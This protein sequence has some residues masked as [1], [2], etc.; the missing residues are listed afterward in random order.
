MRLLVKPVTQK[1]A[2]R[3]AARM[4]RKLDPISERLLMKAYELLANAYLKGKK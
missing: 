2:I 1:Q 3:N 4:G